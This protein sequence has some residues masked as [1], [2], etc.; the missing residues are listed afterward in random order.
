M[1]KKR[2]T[3]E[4]MAEFHRL[5]DCFETILDCLMDASPEMEDFRRSII[6]RAR[7]LELVE[8]KKVTASQIAQ[9]ARESV[10][11][12]SE[13]LMDLLE[14]DPPKARRV[15]D[16]YRG[17]TERDFWEDAGHPKKLIATILQR[18]EIEDESEFRLLNAY[19]C[20]VDQNVMTAQQAEKAN[21][22]LL[23]FESNYKRHV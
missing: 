20:N 18:G 5:S 2:T 7:F 8:E 17:K 11:D 16:A 13:I 4:V 19:A 23:D 12:M 15:L 9:G 21:K 14:D 10:N 6:S 22:M 3:N 1:P